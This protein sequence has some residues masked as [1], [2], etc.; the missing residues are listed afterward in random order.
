MFRRPS[1]ENSSEKLL[2]DEL[3]WP[4]EI[5]TEKDLLFCGEGAMISICSFEEKGFI[6]HI[7]TDGASTGLGELSGQSVLKVEEIQKDQSK[8]VLIELCE[9]YPLF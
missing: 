2:S 9:I 1:P 6:L 5:P 4:Q 8:Q 3:V 7:L